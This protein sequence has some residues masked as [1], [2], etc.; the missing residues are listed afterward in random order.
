MGCIRDLG[1]FV[2]VFRSISDS[3]GVNYEDLLNG[4][5]K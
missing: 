1:D 5:N 2:V 4:E 3:T